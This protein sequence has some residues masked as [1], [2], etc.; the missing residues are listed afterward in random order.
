MEPDVTILSH[1]SKGDWLAIISLLLALVGSLAGIAFAAWAKELKQA[2]E[3]MNKLV[4]H[5]ERM[6]RKL[7]AVELWAGQKDP[8][9]YKLRDKLL[10]EDDD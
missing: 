1:L 3:A 4:R 6:D 10:L 2:R 7:L 5:F 9:F 8:D